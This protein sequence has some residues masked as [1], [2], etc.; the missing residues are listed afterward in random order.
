[1]SYGESLT[2]HPQGRKEDAAYIEGGYVA[3]RA[4]P[5]RHCTARAE[6][7]MHN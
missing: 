3:A 6:R 2:T 7:I 1:M 4:A 5:L